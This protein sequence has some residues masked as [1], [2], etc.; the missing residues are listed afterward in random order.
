MHRRL[1]PSLAFYSRVT[2]IKWIGRG[3]SL[4][5]GRTYKARRR[6]K[7]ATVSSGYGDGYPLAASNQAEVL[8]RGAPFWVG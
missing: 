3:D 4:S 7:V 1:K 5:Y 6:T 8:I 2:H